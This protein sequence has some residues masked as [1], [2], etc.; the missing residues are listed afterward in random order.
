LL[1]PI[2]AFAGTASTAIIAAIVKALI[3]HHPQQSQKPNMEV[4]TNPALLTEHR[5]P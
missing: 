4:V 5:Q 3:F 1:C 2:C